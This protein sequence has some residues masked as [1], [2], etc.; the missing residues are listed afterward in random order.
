MLKTISSRLGSFVRPSSL[1]LAS[2][3]VAC[4][5]AGQDHAR[6]RPPPESLAYTPAPSVKGFFGLAGSEYWTDP[7]KNLKQL[8]WD[9][10]LNKKAGLFAD[11]PGL[12]PIDERKT[13]P[14][15][16]FQSGTAE[17]LARASFSEHGVVALMN[18]DTGHLLAQGLPHATA[19]PQPKNAPSPGF[20]G[21]EHLL[22]L[23]EMFKLPWVRSNYVVTAIAGDTV[24]NR[25]SIALGGS[26]LVPGA[27]VAR[28][29]GSRETLRALD[30][31]LGDPKIRHGSRAG[32]TPAPE[33]IGMSMRLAGAR[34][35]T[36]AWLEVGF[37]LPVRSVTDPKDKTVTSAATISLLVLGSESNVPRIVR[38]VVPST[39]GIVAHSESP[40]GI[41]RFALDLDAAAGLAREPQTYYVY[42]FSGEVLSGPVTVPA[43]RRN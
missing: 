23:T 7:W 13:L 16:V 3:M 5:C 18:L 25:V 40:I 36:H 1:F 14:L 34:P 19:P 9:S 32:E 41:G 42:A 8:A 11:A 2:A 21:V 26:K 22:E 20:A 35:D 15:L 39:G 17:N 10:M 43:S 29:A 28:A 6:E 33:K 30:P 38:L 24:S 37:R 31:P 12:V 27:D 4:A